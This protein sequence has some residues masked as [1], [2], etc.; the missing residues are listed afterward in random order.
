MSENDLRN[1]MLQTTQEIQ[2]EYERIRKRSGEDPGTAGD[3]GEENWKEILA[4]WLPPLYRVVTK[5]RIMNA[6]GICG[7]QVDILVLSPWYP[8]KLLGKKEYL[9]GGV[10]AAFECKLTLNADNVREAVENS[11]A[12]RQNSSHLKAGTPYKDLNH[13]IIFGLLAHSHN[14]KGE[15]STP[16][17]NVEN[18]L[19]TLSD[20][21]VSHPRELID[22]VCVADLAS[23]RIRKMLM[24][25]KTFLNND[26]L[27]DAFKE[28][29]GEFPFEK[30]VIETG[31]IQY[32]T[33]TQ[34]KAEDRRRVTP[35]GNLIS[36]L[37]ERLAWFDD[38]L[39]PLAEYFI[40]AH[41][42]GSGRGTMK[43]WGPDVLSEHVKERLSHGA[44][45][46]S[47]RW[48]EWGRHL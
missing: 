14:W 6:Q 18:H 25:P 17:K 15:K 2:S 44:G 11:I 12:I 5:G 43:F 4:S 19:R 27:M 47:V 1:Y 32:S 3:N 45:V 35:V 42:T 8:D 48:N 26:Q 34:E 9:E 31:Y 41:L 16:I 40:R 33:A 36:C 39:Q 23:W 29:Y 30:G 22:F 24:P 28:R 38:G 10:V 37:L 46:D 21:A 20:S 7:P 13:H